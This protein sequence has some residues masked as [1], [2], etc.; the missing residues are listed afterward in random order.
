M[1]Q[2]NH[3]TLL[4]SILRFYS[5][6]SPV[7]FVIV[8]AYLGFITPG[9][10]HLA[11][12]VSRLAI[13]ANGVHQTFNLIQLA[14]GLAVTGW[15]LTRRLTHPAS[16]RTVKTV[17]AV[18]A[19]CILAAAAFPTDPFESTRFNPAL[20]TTHG[21]M[22]YAVVIGFILLSPAGIW[23]LT[24]SFAREQA[25]ARLS[26]LTAFMGYTALFGCLLWFA[27]YLTGQFTGYLGLI[28][29]SIILWVLGWVMLLR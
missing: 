28:Q 8:T 11:H 5:L 4:F 6:A 3:H 16:I 13:T 12:S 9:Y 14:S 19:A 20:F 23:Q 2:N 18:S 26:R 1:T 27:A 7:V 15:L 29:K 25:F 21:V 24:R 10:N 22:H 17:F